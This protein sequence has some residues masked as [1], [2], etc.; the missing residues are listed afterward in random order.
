MGVVWRA[1]HR[2]SGLPVAI[3]VMTG[4]KANDPAYRAS[5]RQEVRAVAGLDHPGVVLVLDLGEVDAE[6]GAASDHEFVAGSP[7]MAMELASLGTLHEVARPLPWSRLRQVLLGLLDA[8]GHSHSRGIIHRDLKPANILLG[9]MGDRSVEGPD[10]EG[11]WDGTV[12]LTDFGL[13][14]AAQKVTP[15][16]TA[17]LTAGTPHYMAPEQFRGNW[18]DFGPWTDLYALGC[19]AW[20]FALGKLP[21]RGESILSLA[22]AHTV[23]DRP[24]WPEEGAAQ[25]PPGLGDWILRLIQREPEARFQRAAD[26]A[27]VLTR[28]EVPEELWDVIPPPGT[29]H[30]SSV[31]MLPP[32]SEDFYLTVGAE[33]APG[34]APPPSQSPLGAAA[35]FGGA[36]ARMEVVDEGLDELPRSGE[37]PPIPETWRRPGVERPSMKLRGA[38]L[39]LFGVRAVPLVG[40][41]QARDVLWGALRDVESTGRPRALLLH[42]PAGTGKT[43]LGEWLGR[44]AHEVGAATVL[45]AVHAPIPGPDHGLEAML[46][47]HLGVVGLESEELVERLEQLLEASGLEAEGESRELAAVLRPNEGAGPSWED[48][49]QALIRT[50]THLTTER[51]V[52]LLLNDVGWARDTLAAVTQLLRAPRQTPLPILV[53]MTARDDDL[54]AAGTADEIDD[55]LDIERTSR[56]EIGP[57]P[58]G[59]RQALVAEMLG[60]RTGLAARIDERTEGSP[61]FLVQLVGDWVER[62]LLVPGD[63]GF[64]LAPGADEGLPDDL[65]TVAVHRLD[66]ALRGFGDHARPALEAAAAL[67]S[68]VDLGEWT[69]VCL[70]QELT[71]PLGDILERLLSARLAVPTERGFSFATAMLREALERLAAEAGRRADHHRACASMLAE[72]GTD[73]GE[74]RGLHLLAGGALEDALGPLLEGA[75]AHQERS[76][77]RGVL[78][79]LERRTRALGSLALSEDDPRRGAGRALEAWAY[80]VL[81]NL[82]RAEELAASAEADGERFGH[83]ATAAEAALV[84][85]QVAHARGDFEA[86]RTLH[87]RARLLCREAGLAREATQAIQALADVALRGGRVEDAARLFEQAG[88]LFDRLGRSVEHADC[89]RARALCATRQGRSDEALHLLQTALQTYDAAG[90]RRGMADT[91]NSLAERARKDGRLADAEDGYRRALAL[92][93]A[94]G[95]GGEMPRIN[96]ALLLLGLDRTADAARVLDPA[97]ERLRAAGRRGLL[98][99]ALAAAVPCR[100]GE[101]RWGSFTRTLAEAR[102]LL[103][104]G[105]IAETD[106]A[107]ALER[108]GRLARA[109][110]RSVEAADAWALAIE[111]WRGADRPDEAARLEAERSSIEGG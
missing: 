8:L 77:P 46:A 61:Q 36:T 65:H 32:A 57:L 98:G 109:D 82:D 66:A 102:E 106:V 60:F 11:A 20:E 54:A 88:A 2:S 7:W 3:K 23:G 78:A 34:S 64:E 86:S 31:A 67:G 107:E 74:R 105:Q 47:A 43:A 103:R 15:T 39:G 5:F 29:E 73:G 50:L 92:H 27:W 1:V 21:F 10:D 83:P 49:H 80:R 25:L 96:L 58:D 97:I 13:A 14:H 40:R 95:V 63:E 45:R 53:L 87:Q 6:A 93:E 37:I 99:C 71:A 56:L 41:R 30:H 24:D 42:G 9:C 104:A 19:L 33:S 68:E 18:R 90:N 111:Q 89:L 101:R 4:A 26:A 100:A 91:L 52:L 17:L 94:T 22:F 72:L 38:G 28:L 12:R 76:D 84:R 16:H 62:G 110:G 55:L 48:R 75:R 85:A 69:Q 59:D 51:T 44:R 70:D 81:G 35:G 108:G 79:L